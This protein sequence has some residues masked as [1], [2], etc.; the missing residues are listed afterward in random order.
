MGGLMLN[1]VSFADRLNVSKDSIF[2]F[3]ALLNPDFIGA[4]GV[5]VAYL[6][7]DAPKGAPGPPR[8]KPSKLHNSLQG[9]PQSC[10]SSA[11]L[12]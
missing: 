12:S 8:S 1:S 3:F 10:S 2:A 9:K 5:F 11:N 7:P 6:P 4:K